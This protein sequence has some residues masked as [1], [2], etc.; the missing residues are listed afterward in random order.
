MSFSKSLRIKPVKKSNAPGPGSYSGWCI[1]SKLK[2]DPA[3]SLGTAKRPDATGGFQKM[4][5]PGPGQ[6][7]AVKAAE[8]V[9]N[10]KKGK[11]ITIGLKLENQGFFRHQL[12]L[13]D[14]KPGPGDHDV[15]VSLSAKG[16][17]IGQKVKGGG[18]MRTSKYEASPASYQIDAVK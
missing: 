14:K 8:A 7:D 12:D 2:N 6:Y 4:F 16:G 3:F 10:M 9:S 15:K 13:R 1:T 17:Y 5:M 11:S 18:I